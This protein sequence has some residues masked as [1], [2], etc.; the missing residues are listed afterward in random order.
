M[1]IYQGKKNNATNFYKKNKCYIILYNKR[2]I[3]INIKMTL[4]YLLYLNNKI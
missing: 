2:Y 3:L 1:H 4:V